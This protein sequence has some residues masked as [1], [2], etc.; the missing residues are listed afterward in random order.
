MRTSRKLIALLLAVML[1]FGLLASVP[2]TASAA[3]GLVTIAQGDSLNTIQTSIQTTLDGMGAGDVLTVE[4]SKTNA[5]GLLEIT[6]PA[7]VKV[8]WGAVIK[9]HVHIFLA[10]SGTFEVAEGA[11]IIGD[12][13]DTISTWLYSSEADFDFYGHILVSGGLVENTDYSQ[14]AIHFGPGGVT[15][16]GGTVR[17]KGGSSN[18]A[19]LYGD[20]A[21]VKVTGGLI[22]VT[23]DGGYAIMN[24]EGDTN[25]CGGSV[26]A[27]GANSCALLTTSGKIKVAGGSV[28]AAGAG[29]YAMIIGSNGVGAYL[30]GT[31][32]GGLVIGDGWGII[33]E[34]ST[35]DIPAA[36]DG[37]SEGITIK[38]VNNWDPADG[39]QTVTWDTSVDPPLLVFDLVGGNDPIRTIEW[40]ACS[41]AP[42]P[43]GISG[44]ETMTVVEG[45]A[46]FA[47]DP[48]T[49][50]G[51]PL[52]TVTISGNP[53]I[54]WNAATQQLDIAAGLAPGTYTVV[55]TASNG[56]EP[57]ATATFTLIVVPASTPPEPKPPVPPTG[58]ALSLLGMISVSSLA[59]VSL[60][61]GVVTGRKRH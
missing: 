25:I 27:D 44:P 17:S 45:Y 22:E 52:P 56:V 40:F 58:D 13:G 50:T 6:I 23:D 15:V 38:T 20:D 36:W 31:C 29:G 32:T 57:D 39:E 28:S 21:T 47:T 60:G 42:I 35:L 9:D 4:G 3:S 53:A 2:L 16:T 14:D 5:D 55:L 37:T 19:T 49:L 51:S 61:M 7:D 43:P 30:A 11:E 18:N 12:G 1:A 34:V 41:D 24:F 33:V 54:T 10:G 46:A 26:I 8:I 59:L 48:F